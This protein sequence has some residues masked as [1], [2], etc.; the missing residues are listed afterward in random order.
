MSHE[1]SCVP[2]IPG[3]CPWALSL[4][5]RCTGSRWA[6]SGHPALVRNAGCPD[7]P[8]R[9]L[10]CVDSTGPSWVGRG[11]AQPVVCLPTFCDWTARRPGWEL[12]NQP[13]CR[14]LPGPWLPAEMSLSP[15]FT[16][17]RPSSS[18]RRVGAKQ[19]LP[20]LATESRL[21]APCLL[22]M[23]LLSGKDL[24]ESPLPSTPA[25]PRASP[26]QGIP[27]GRGGGS[28]PSERP[29]VHG[30]LPAGLQR[31]P[32]CWKPHWSKDS[33]YFHEI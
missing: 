16:A 20:G 15:R 2:R 17:R 27:A 9:S 19:G 24:V 14:L 18:S 3:L 32:R 21:P 4:G 30:A 13:Q 6:L 22:V 10:W 28:R 31:R 25:G 1:D 29:H 33:G 7:L 5:L 8:R 26:A 11:Q 12:G 23:L